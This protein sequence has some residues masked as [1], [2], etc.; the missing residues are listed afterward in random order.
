LKDSISNLEEKKAPEVRRKGR[1][2]STA[3]EKTKTKKKRK[4]MWVKLGNCWAGVEFLVRT[5][6][7]HHGWRICNDLSK[8]GRT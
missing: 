8:E 4:R 7:F 1:E 6:S 3:K 5:N 2:K